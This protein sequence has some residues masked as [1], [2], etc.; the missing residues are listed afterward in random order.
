MSI[1]G[2]PGTRMVSRYTRA[3][4]TFVVSFVAIMQQS[5]DQLRAVLGQRL[6]RRPSA[7]MAIEH[8]VQLIGEEFF[9]A[10][11]RATAVPLAELIIEAQQL[12]AE[13]MS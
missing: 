13:G 11:V 12:G 10:N 8:T 4:T 6:V 2:T 7:A 3:M 9:Q 5:G 1:S